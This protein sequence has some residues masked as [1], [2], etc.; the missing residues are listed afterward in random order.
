[1]PVQ[2]TFSD[3]HHV[4]Y[5]RKRLWTRRP[6]GRA[7]V[8]VGAGFSRNSVP[9][10]AGARPFPLWRQLVELLFDGLYPVHPMAERD[11]QID[12]AASGAGALT[13]ALQYEATFGRSALDNLLLSAIPDEEHSPGELHRLLLELPWADVFTVNY[14]TLLERTRSQVFNRR[15]EVVVQLSD[16]PITTPP[17]IIKLHG[18][19]PATKPFIFTE[20]DFRRYPRQFAPF[21][22][23]VQQGMMENDVVLLGFSGDDPNFLAWLGWVRD[24]LLAVRPQVYLCGVLDITSAQRIILE[25]RGVTPID[26]GTLFPKS[27]YPGNTA[28][29]HSDALHWLLAS[30]ENGR[31]TLV[32]VSWP[33]FPDLPDYRA[34]RAD[35]GIGPLDLAPLA[36]EEPA[37]CE[38]KQFFENGESAEEEQQLQ[39]QLTCWVRNR[40]AYPGWIVLPRPNRETLRETTNEWRKPLVDWLLTKPLAERL[41][42][43]AE[44]IWRLERAFMVF[45]S[46][47]EYEL[48]SQLIQEL[49]LP[50][51]PVARDQWAS[52]AFYLLRQVRYR[53]QHAEFEQLLMQLER[54]ALVAPAYQAWRCWEAATERLEHLDAVGARRWLTRWP[55][56]PDAPVWDVRR[57][58]L[59]AEL[60]EVEVGERYAAQALSSARARQPHGQ[61]RVAMLSVEEA[62]TWRLTQLRDEGELGR[63]ELN[64]SARRQSSRDRERQLLFKEYNCASDEVGSL[65]DILNGPVPE[66]QV[67]AYRSVDSYTGLY[68]YSRRSAVAFSLAWVQPA[69]DMPAIF[70]DSGQPMR[71]DSSRYRELNAAVKWLADV[72]PYRALGIIIRTGDYE[73]LGEF[74]DP[75][76][77]VWMAEDRLLA[78]LEPAVSLLETRLASQQTPSTYRE[79]DN[80]RLALRLVGRVMFRLPQQS[81]LRERVIQLARRV[82]GTWPSGLSQR[83]G[84]DDG[85]YNEFTAGVVAALQSEE[86]LNLLSELLLAVPTPQ[87]LNGPFYYVAPE[88]LTGQPPTGLSA[89]TDEL[90]TWLRRGEP[91]REAAASR[92]FLLDRLGW[93][94]GDERQQFARAVWK[95]V[96]KGKMP[97]LDAVFWPWR[98]LTLPEPGNRSGQKVIRE[99]LLHSAGQL[100][101]HLATAKSGTPNAWSRQVRYFTNNCALVAAPEPGDHLLS[102]EHPTQWITW[103]E[104]EALFLLNTVSAYV[105]FI[106]PAL[107]TLEAQYHGQAAG[108]SDVWETDFDGLSLF[109]RRVVLPALSNSNKLQ[110][111]K[112]FIDEALQLQLPVRAALPALLS[113]YAAAD[114]PLDS[115]TYSSLI[116]LG[117][118]DATNADTVADSAEAVYQ[119]VSRALRGHLAEDYRPLFGELL[120]R[121]RMRDLPNTTAVA[122]E[123][124]HLLRE[125][126]TVLWAEYAEPLGQVLEALLQQTAEPTWV[127]RLLARRLIE[128]EQLFQRPRLAEQ[129]AEIAG[130]VARLNAKHPH[131]SST[132]TLAKWQARVEATLYPAVRRAWRRG[133]GEAG[134]TRLLSGPAAS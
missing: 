59:W 117:L 133:L 132:T 72:Q 63:A 28:Q 66:Y 10:I 74:L 21:V 54:L 118:L 101:D 90:L 68:S 92:L 128:R 8:M 76:R 38:E 96:L 111:A 31:S 85:L 116:R 126:A 88:L 113:H 13:M 23:T 39:Q 84:L 3:L 94:R 109:L 102:Q 95:T 17:R 22:N 91:W 123:L 103:T 81:D 47:A 112:Q 48:C 97:S 46:K 108:M 6:I 37:Y 4:A 1:M 79:R 107:R 56:V 82:W 25:K 36:P 19:F 98:L 99:F 42:P 73:Q 131:P 34:A 18:S 52:I 2:P 12:Q 40:L 78:L 62:A 110:V 29:R 7:A 77:V 124:L 53:Y 24:E 33:H 27:A 119:W 51:A 60:G 11:K 43:L 89:V 83:L 122:G 41:A 114:Q 121:L 80:I 86:V 15:Y 115:T 65:T 57:A 9:Q 50:S 134:M 70:E 64:T 129:A 30:L 87:S 20:E 35:A 127:D 105:H 44:L 55:E 93:L 104:N 75:A 69:L 67:A 130:I 49:P 32:P 14:D 71:L 26:L 45:V 5:L 58:G 100:R 120:L 16:L 106:A 125:F 61:V